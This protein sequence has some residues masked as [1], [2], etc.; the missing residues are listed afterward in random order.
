MRSIVA[1][2]PSSMLVVRRRAR[3][4]AA[5]RPCRRGR[6][7]TPST[8]R[9]S[10][11]SPGA[12]ARS[13]VR[14]AAVQAMQLLRRRPRRRARASARTAGSCAA[15][16]SR[17]SSRERVHVQ[18]QRLLDLG[19]VEQVAEALGRELR[20]V[21]EHDR[22]AEHR[23]VLGVGEHRQGV[24]VSHCA[25]PALRARAARRSAPPR[26]RARRRAWR[27]GECAQRLARGRG[28]RATSV[29]VVDADRHAHAV[30][31]ER[32]AAQPTRPR[33]AVE[34][35]TARPSRL[36]ERVG[37]SSTARST[38]WWRSPLA[39][40]KRTVAASVAPAPRSS[41]A[42]DPQRGRTSRRCPPR[43]PAGRRSRTASASRSSSRP[44]CTGRARSPRRAASRR[45]LE[46]VTASSQQLRDAARRR[47]AARARPCARCERGRASRSCS[48][49]QP[50]PG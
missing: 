35:R 48:R 38:P 39:W 22:R 8:D 44:A 24:D 25:T 42:L 33:S 16:A 21:G 30:A 36:A 11:A 3:R 15:I 5:A 29:V 45:A 37:G 14:H 13:T 50:P 9:R 17:S 10:P 41:D 6:S 18:Q 4:P 1:V 28:P 12:R 34:R 43:R 19:G 46:R 32:L 23:V 40:R 47:T 49:T 20:V 27:A 31:V 7:V 2:R 26:D